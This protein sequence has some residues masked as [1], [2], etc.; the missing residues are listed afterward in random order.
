MSDTLKARNAALWTGAGYE[1]VNTGS[2]QWAAQKIVNGVLFS[3]VDNAESDM[4]DPD[5]HLSVSAFDAEA[6]EYLDA[7]WEVENLT[8]IGQLI[9]IWLHEMGRGQPTEPA[10]I[11]LVELALQRALSAYAGKVDKGGQPYIL[12]PIRVMAAFTHPVAQAVA[13]LHDVIEDSATTAE[14]LRADGFPE[15][16]VAG[17]LLLTRQPG[18][19]YADYIERAGSSALTRRIKQEDL[20]DN[21]DFKRLT[22]VTPKDQERMAKYLKAWRRLEE[23]ER[24]AR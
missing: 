17:V 22:Q 12:H 6:L 2:Q 24:A 3:V 7:C 23:L 18:E 1:I 20:R 8:Q 11:N 16:V 19:S 14:E 4:P 5:G 21:M 13:L 10:P 15:A 9:P